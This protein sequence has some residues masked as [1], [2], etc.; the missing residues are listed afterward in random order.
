MKEK[1]PPYRGFVTL[2]EQLF[3]LRF[4]IASLSKIPGVGRIMYL[5][6]F[7]HNNIT[8]LPKD[9]SIEIT[10]NKNL[11]PTENMILPSEIVHKFIDI[12]SYHFIMDF[13]LCREAMQ[14]NKYPQT[15]GCLF[16]GE[17]I[18]EI[19]P[20]YGHQVTAIEAHKHIKKCQEAGLIHIIGR[21]KIDETWLQVSSGDKLM[22]ICNCCECC[23]LWKMLPHLNEQIN[24]RYKKMPGVT[25]EVTDTCTGC[26]TC[27]SACFLEGIRIID[28]KAVLSDNCRGC[29]R[30]VE[31]CPINAIKITIDDEYYIE[32]TIRN[33]Q[34]SV[35]VT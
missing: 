31:K 17:A 25:I 28:K 9:N 34:K 2:L 7:R 29:G 16:L 20:K 21:D 1:K 6:M 15:L 12:S 4:P 14:C 30:C 11:Q 27:I 19:N 10:L 23:C 33:I 5:M 24:T 8:L 3:P 22:T 32:K 35:T 26:G 18:K 13:C